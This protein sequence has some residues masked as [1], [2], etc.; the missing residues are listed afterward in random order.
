MPALPFE[1]TIPDSPSLSTNF[2][3]LD[4]NNTYTPPDT[5]GAV[6][7]NR[8]M[9][10]L[11]GQVRIQDRGGTTI[12]NTTLNAW[13]S[14][15]G[16]FSDNTTNFVFD[17]HLIYDPFH[18]RWIA[19]AVA[20]LASPGASLLLGASATGDPGGAWHLY[21]FLVDPNGLNWADFPLIGFNRD[22][23]AVSFTYIETS[24][25]L[26]NGS[27][28]AI[29]DRATLYSGGTFTSGNNLNMTNIASTFG[30]G[31]APALTYDT[32]QSRLYL[33]Q[34]TS[35]SPGR[36][37]VYPINGSAGSAT[38]GAGAGT[39]SPSWHPG[40]QINFA[41]QLGTTNKINLLDH[42]IVQPI[43]RFGT[44]WFAHTIM[45]PSSI[46]TRSL[47]QWWQ[48]NPTN[49]TTIQRGYIEDSSAITNYA[50][51]SIAV[52][53][54]RDVMVGFSVFSS[55]N[56][57]GAAY[58]FRA[59]NDS[60]S[61]MQ[62]PGLLKAGVSEYWRTDGFGRN[63]WGDY[64]ATQVD[65][66]NDID[67]WTIQEYAAQYVGTLTNGSGRWGTWWGKLAPALPGND[68]F[69]SAFAITNAQGASNGTVL[70]ATREAG[71]PSHSGITN[72]PSVWYQWVASGSG[73]TLFSV[74]NRGVLFDTVIAVYTGSAVGSL[75][76]VTNRHLTGGTNVVFSA[77]SGTTYR[78]A[79]AGY[80][81]SCG[82]FALNWAAPSAPM[83]IDQP[84]GTNC[85]ANVNEAAVFTV[86]AI[87]T[88]NPVY[89]W[90]FKGTNSGSSTTNISG[91]TNTS[92]T[93]ANVQ[94]NHAGDYSVVVTNS[95]GSKTS[96]VATLFI[97]G[98]SAARL[99]LVG[100]N[101][102][103]Y[104]FQIYGLTNRP[105]VVQTSTNLGSSTNWYPIYTN[106]VSFYYTN[107]NRTS[108]AQRFYRAITN[109]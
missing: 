20:N 1:P 73:S 48:I 32:N 65:P 101:S 10:M 6:G 11:N 30:Y 67:L 103:S 5:M 50:F 53:R 41:E 89:Q 56:Y 54:F 36:I 63:R 92:H 69:A 35:A 14:S 80:N 98:D 88:P 71:E 60:V 107:F 25:T 16:P 12:S 2:S 93:I 26:G 79:V 59:C 17:P 38:I 90:R 9:I 34:A 81:G 4:D 66:V 3:G 43:Y 19:T 57:A 91:A 78:I 94:T 82:D 40:G 37:A 85:V 74:T 55:S 70:R 62:A 105:Y 23:V 27:A 77:A 86:L 46:P 96:T 68:S 28:V 76:L 33:V 22:K 58:A 47:I 49:A 15:V 39:L 102:T 109:N 84:V 99:N 87:G 52:N 108:D 97:H 21:A 100:L 64:S 44:L 29:F 95:S 51:P 61:T 13:W 42:R 7:T 83:I 72:T 24:T 75:T 18:H 45:L 8:L 104:W 106:F 31:L